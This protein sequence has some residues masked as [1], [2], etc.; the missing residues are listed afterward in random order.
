MAVEPYLVHAIWDVGPEVRKKI[1]DQGR[2]NLH[3]VR[4]ILRFHDVT[5]IIFDGENSRTSFDVEVDL[6]AKKR[7]VPL[8]N[9]GRAYLAEI[10]TV[11]GTG[12]FSPLARS[13]VTETPRN[14]ITLQSE[15][16]FAMV[17]EGEVPRGVITEVSPESLSDDRLQA[18]QQNDPK[19]SAT[20]DDAVDLPVVQGRVPATDVVMKKVQEDRRP[21]DTD[22]RFAIHARDVLVRG[23]LLHR[24]WMD[25]KKV[26]RPGIRASRMIQEQEQGQKREKVV[27]LTERSEKTFVAGISSK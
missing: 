17:Q 7:Y 16:Q 15:P 1:M 24:P 3:P 13:N 6:S 25:A 2:D 21:G 10:G 9:A 26:L 22:N 4:F 12:V 27:D 11:N 20:T 19:T 8:R 23:N 5:D 18:E 14:G